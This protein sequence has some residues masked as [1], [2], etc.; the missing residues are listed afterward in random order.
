MKRLL[1]GAAVLAAVPGFG[2]TINFEP[3]TYTGSASGTVVTGQDGWYL[4]AAGGIDH[5]VYTY[6]GNALGVPVNPFG[7][8]QFMGGRTANAAFARAQ[9]DVDMSG[10]GLWIAEYDISISFSGVLPATLNNSSFSLQ[11]PQASVQSFIA[12]NNF[13]DAATATT[14]HAHYNIYDS[15]G[16]ALSD[17]DPGAGFNGLAVNHWYRQKTIWSFDTHKVME[18]SMTDLATAT[19]TTFV[20]TD[21]FLNGGD[22]GGGLPL[23]TAFRAFAGGND[24]NTIALDNL[25]VS[26]VPEPAS[27]LALGL[28]V[29]L[30]ASRRR[31]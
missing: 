29:L 6:A 8:T 9:H 18:I 16:A 22:S 19:T 24:G 13:D 1:M 2:L 12:L 26:P 7:G 21:W 28:G 31:R 30:L 23:P 15:F 14:W 11:D 17:V 3:A 5:M 10:G 4:P 20:P 25:N 27:V